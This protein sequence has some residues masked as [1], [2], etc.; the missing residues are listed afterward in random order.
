MVNLTF[1]EL[2][3]NCLLEIIY[4]C[5]TK[6]VMFHKILERLEVFQ[7]NFPGL[8]LLLSCLMSIYGGFKT[9]IWRGQVFLIGCQ[10]FRFS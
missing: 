10:A 3:Y 7:S 6:E 5:T 4:V 9:T 8:S 1:S 2:L